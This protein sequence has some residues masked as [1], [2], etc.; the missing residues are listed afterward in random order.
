M[1][2]KRCV[3]EWFKAAILL[4]GDH[5]ILS[6]L[7]GCTRV[8]VELGETIEESSTRESHRQLMVNIGDQLILC[9]A[10]L[11]EI[12]SAEVTSISI[13]G[14]KAKI[15][16]SLGYGEIRSPIVSILRGAKA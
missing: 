4:L 11:D 13:D 12:Q 9:G 2:V 14:W 6:P 1:R 5:A 3:R 7:R 10:A 16:V 8:V 15:R